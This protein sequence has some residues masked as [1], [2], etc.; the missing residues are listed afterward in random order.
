MAELTTENLD[1][2]SRHIYKCSYNRLGCWVRKDNIRD[3]VRHMKQEEIN[4]WR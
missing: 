4:S 1:I 2:V 3:K